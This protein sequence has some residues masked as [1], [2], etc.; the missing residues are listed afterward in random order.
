MYNKCVSH[1]TYDLR[2]WCVYWMTAINR[3]REKRGANTLI[4]NEN[5]HTHTNTHA[6]LASSILPLLC[7]LPPHSILLH[8]LCINY[9]IGNKGKCLTGRNCKWAGIDWVVSHTNWLQTSAANNKK[10]RGK[11]KRA[12]LKLGWMVRDHP[13][14]NHSQTCKII[15]RIHQLLY[16]V[17]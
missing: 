10:G 1:Q 15:I 16:T 5:T 14:S 2:W 12:E 6:T 7:T 17:F 3:R 11:G 9:D 13:T 8:L 4:D